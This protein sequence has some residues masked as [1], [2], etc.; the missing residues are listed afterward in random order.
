MMSSSVNAGNVVEAPMIR[1]A[2]DAS[3]SIGL[4]KSARNYRHGEA[5]SF[6]TGDVP[7]DRQCRVQMWRG[8]R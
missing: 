8:A 7:D 3:S 4:G 5:Q 6:G 1:P 2:L